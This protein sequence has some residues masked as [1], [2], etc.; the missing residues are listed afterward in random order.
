[1]CNNTVS[2]YHYRMYVYTNIACMCVCVC[3]CVCVRAC[4]CVYVCVCMYVRTYVRTYVCMRIHVLG[5]YTIRFIVI[6]KLNLSQLLHTCLSQV[7]LLIV[8]VHGLN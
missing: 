3:V 7:Y 4:V 6:A 8:P 2:C 5:M 1:M